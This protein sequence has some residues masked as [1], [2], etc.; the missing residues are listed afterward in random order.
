MTNSQPT[1]DTELFDLCKQVYEKTGWITGWA[2]SRYW[3]YQPYDG[4]RRREFYE[5]YKL[6]TF[7]EVDQLYG[8][9]SMDED[10][11][12]FTPLYTSDYLLEK[13]PYWTS[14]TKEGEYASFPKGYQFSAQRVNEA[15]V[16]YADAPL[17]ALLKLTL[18]LHKSGELR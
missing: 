11:E 17:K 1:Q 4:K 3:V 7:D 14:V 8:A 6:L 10:K 2:G 18:A 15:P 9:G 12:S 13:L 5:K 16:L